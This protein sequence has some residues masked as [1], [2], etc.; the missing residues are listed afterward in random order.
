MGRN[1]GRPERGD[2]RR[3]RERWK[4]KTARRKRESNREMTLEIS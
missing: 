3:G 1:Y 2:R 4:E